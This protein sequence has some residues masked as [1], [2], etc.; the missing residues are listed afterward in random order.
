M[1]FKIELSELEPH[2]LMCTWCR[3]SFFVIMSI[4]DRFAE[5]AKLSPNFELLSGLKASAKASLLQH[6]VSAMRQ[7]GVVHLLERVVRSPVIIM[8]SS[9]CLLIPWRPAKL[10]PKTPRLCRGISPFHRFIGSTWGK[11]KLQHTNKKAEKSEI[12][13]VLIS[14]K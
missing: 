14:N 2:F 13:I 3:L 7:W 9:V 11:V 12:S 10:L 4:Y 6:L 8:L 1:S 5:V